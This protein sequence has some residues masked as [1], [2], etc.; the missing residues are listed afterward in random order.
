M[1][2][3]AERA[4]A[5]RREFAARYGRPPAGVYRAPGRVN[6]IGEHTD[7]NDGFV[8]P[9]AIGLSAW[10]A[11]APRADRTVRLSSAQYNDAVTFTLDDTAAAT[12]HWSAPLAGVVATLAERYGLERGAD[13][14]LD[15]EVPIGA[16]LSSSAAAQAAVGLAAAEE[17]GLEVG[18]AE[19]ARICQR[20]SAEFAG[21]RCGIMDPYIAL[22]GRAASVLRLDTRSLR[23]R[24][25]AWPPP[26]CLLVCDSGVR[27]DHAASE[28][29][30]RRVE[31][32]AAVEALAE[33]APGLRSLRDA[34]L[35]TI[36]VQGAGLEETLRRRARHVV[37]ENARVVEAADALAAGD[38]A[39]LGRLMSASHASLR[40]DYQVSCAELDRLQAACAALPEVYGARMMGGGFGG[41]VL[42]LTR[43]ES[44]AAVRRALRGVAARTWLCRPEAGA[45]RVPA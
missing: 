12:G 40:D 6:L 8:M 16:G 32:E 42:A 39:Q 19:L 24:W 15:S 30:L 14:W 28:Y 34:S 23:E 45:E 25:I 37:S 41:C 26:A 7:Y 20:A 13:L 2:T 10:A 3:G 35:E 22:T 33:R 36:A 11:I 29:N 38:L 5:L 4:A 18:R 17:A 44:G 27:H 43:A 31:C 21:V 9:L 1:G